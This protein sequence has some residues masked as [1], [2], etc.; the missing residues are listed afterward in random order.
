MLEAGGGL[1]L[2][3]S[4]KNRRLSV[5]VIYVPYDAKVD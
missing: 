4:E 2:E 1:D 3:L 5:F